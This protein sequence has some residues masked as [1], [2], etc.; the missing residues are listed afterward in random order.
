[1]YMPINIQ[2]ILIANIHANTI[3]TRILYLIDIFNIGLILF[4]I[5]VDEIVRL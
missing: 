5:F 4:G 3:T 2:S 1:M